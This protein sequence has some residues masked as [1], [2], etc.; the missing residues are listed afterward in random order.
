MF[1]KTTYY[2][3][4][5]VSWLLVASGGSD[6]QWTK[7]LPSVFMRYGYGVRCGRDQ[8]PTSTTDST[9]PRQPPRHMSI[10]YQLIRS[11]RMECDIHPHC[12]R[13]VKIAYGIMSDTGAGATI[14]PRQRF[15]GPRPI[16][17]RAGRPCACPLCFSR[18][19]SCR[20]RPRQLVD[21]VL[22]GCVVAM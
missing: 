1:V 8:T 9:A 6:C 11:N 15:K 21:Y 12:K 2:P 14:R 10:A 19:R 18:G 16:R 5:C 4:T 22:G 3:L 7:P 13:A 20:L 17:M